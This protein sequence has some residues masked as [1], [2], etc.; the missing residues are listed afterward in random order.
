MKF[1]VGVRV[2]GGVTGTREGLLKKD[3]AVQEFDTREA[4]EAEVAEYHKRMNNQYARA[5]F[6]AWVVPVN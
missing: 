3:G 2:S 4:A 1:N 5:S 6:E